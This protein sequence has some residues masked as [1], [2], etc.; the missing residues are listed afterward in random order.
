MESNV[1][2]HRPRRTVWSDSSH[3]TDPYRNDD[4]RRGVA[5]PASLSRLSQMLG[6][7][8][9]FIRCDDGL[10]KIGWTS[11]IAQRKRAF[12]SGWT[13]ILAVVPG[14][15]ADERALHKRFAAHRARGREYYNPDAE[16][17]EYVNEIR[18]RLGVQPI[19]A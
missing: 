1:T 15:L 3:M 8:V 17:V 18:S 10:I 16:I 6:D 11:N 2:K 14:S 9:Y 13:R 19:A 5:Q 12:G 4:E 7:C